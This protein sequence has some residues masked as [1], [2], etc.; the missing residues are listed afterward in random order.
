MMKWQQEWSRGCSNNLC[1][2]FF[3]GGGK[4]MACSKGR[5]RDVANQGVVDLKGMGFQ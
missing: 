2:N 4:K 3:F 1:L 5:S